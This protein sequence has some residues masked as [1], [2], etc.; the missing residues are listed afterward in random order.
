[1]PNLSKSIEIDGVYFCWDEKTDE[2]Y[3]VSA[4]FTLVDDASKH[5]VKTLIKKKQ[6]GETKQ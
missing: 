4:E 1:M 6:K 3:Q 5:A 2:V